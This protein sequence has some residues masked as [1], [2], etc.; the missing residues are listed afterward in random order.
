LGPHLD[1]SQIEELLRVSAN[2]KE[3][4]ANDR[5]D[6]NAR[7]H[8]NDC[9][10]CQARVR[11][12][13]EAMERLAQLKSGKTGTPNTQC[14]PDSAWLELA[15]RIRPNPESLLRHAAQCDHCGPLL[16]DAVADLTGECT[17]QEEA[18]IADLASA[19]P[20]WQKDLTRSL[21]TSAWE[22][23]HPS[24]SKPASAQPDPRPRRPRFW[25][26]YTVAA[27][28]LIILSTWAVLHR[29]TTRSAQ[30]LLADAYSEHRTLELRIPGAKHAPVHLERGTG[31]SNLDKPGSLLRAESIIAEH[32]RKKPNDVEFL[33]AKARA[34]LIDGNFDSAIKTLQRAMEAR[35]LSPVLMTDLAT[36]YFARAEATDQ[37]ID[38]GRAIDNLGKVLAASP[39]DSLAL[40]NRAITEERMLLYDE[41]I[42]DWEHFLRVEPDLAWRKEGKDR[43]E[44]LRHKMEERKHST[45]LPIRDPTIA[46]AALRFRAKSAQEKTWP[47]TLDED[48]LNIAT[49]EWLP[50]ISSQSNQPHPGPGAWAALKELSEQLRRRHHDDWLG[51]LINGSHSP[52]WAEGSRELAAALRADSA[53]DIGEIV[54][55]AAK[56][57][58]LF[59]LAGNQ[60]GE[61]GAR[62]EY[63]SGLNRSEKGNDCLPAANAAL[64]QTHNRR[65]PR[66]EIRALYERSTCHFL[67]GN[68]LAAT[69]DA[70]RAEAL[71]V[72]AQYPVLQLKGLYYL[73]GV[74]TSWVASSE[75]WDQIRSG[76]RVFWRAPNPPSAAADF[77]GDLGSAAETEKMWWT[78]ERAGHESILM[79]SLGHD[80]IQEAAAHHSL[81]QVA[82]AE[83]N[84]ALADAEYQRATAVLASSGTDIRAASATLEIER[85]AL[86]VR[87]GKF[88]S[89]ATRLDAIQPSLAGFSKEYATILYLETLGALHIHLGKP[90]LAKAELLQ[91]I[92]LI[93]SNQNTLDSDTALFAWQ[94]NT[95]EAYKSMVELYNQTYHDPVRSFALLEWFRAAPLRARQTAHETTPR[96]SDA[97]LD[98]PASAHLSGQIGL[99]VGTAVITW[100]PFP[101]GLA[102]WLVDTTGVHSAWVDVS[103]DR[104]ESVVGTFA[105][106][107]SDPLSD[108]SLVDKAGRQLYEWL[109][110]PVSAALRG[111]TTL[112]IEPGER[113]NAV[114]FQAL[115]GQTG[116]YLGDRFLIIESPGLGYS[117]LLRS[118]RLVSSKSMILAVGNPLLNASDGLP[119]LA[120]ADR[121][122]H[123]ISAKFTRYHLLTGSEATITNVLAWLP[124]AEVFHFAGHT[125]AQGRETGLLLASSATGKT[126]LLEPDQMRPQQMKQLKLAV[127]SACDTAVADG[128]LNDPGSLVRLFLRA[129]VPQVIASKW[130]VDSAAS[131]QL[132]ENLY[133]RLLDGDS[134]ELAL[135]SA[136]RQMRSRTETSHPYY[137][138]AFSEFGGG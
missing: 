122:A 43:L 138:A 85:A 41:A 110:E 101:S 92:R 107:C 8:L 4:S 18:Q 86:E 89:E 97:R 117:K 5:I 129:G 130:P 127:L 70:H 25:L 116:E 30:L 132:M 27:M 114:P 113:L 73:D 120:N 83:G 34:D 50:T 80:R 98:L 111:A 57:I 68:P 84:D 10:I 21:T 31:L 52:A 3:D 24:G 69:D 20:K 2:K 64:E 82:E 100:M 126:A 131:S 37:A 47:L 78:A 135:A 79:A 7:I 72:A 112:V 66:I 35:P 53:G 91:A 16:R 99:K 95:A 28:V 96:V 33:D 108:T 102:I 56:S 119:S 77:Y 51:D 63:A 32:L 19:T 125:L 62:L 134:V 90:D 76:L 123:D 136:E 9:Y 46:I 81:A 104:L 14:P 39:D 11:A 17:P 87:Q 55:H 124:Q 40:F 60:A 36:A 49:T 59:R 133:A 103:Q 48:Y 65:Y 38:Y 93:E 44:D 137:W 71:A 61:A 88:A 6:A 75:S 94:R 26:L 121:E 29:S 67:N 58:S 105:R 118:D 109:L 42:S 128:G 12:E 23:P 15:A 54:S 74:T 106:L 45:V 115:K 1:S 13:G 22:S